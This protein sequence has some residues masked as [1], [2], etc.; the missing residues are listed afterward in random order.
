[1]KTNQENR[2]VSEKVIQL[3]EK[4]HEFIRPLSIGYID[5]EKAFNSIEHEVIF[6]ALRTTGIKET[7][8]T[9][10]EDIY[11][12]TTARVHTDNQVSEE[13]SILRGVRQG[14]QISPKSFIAAIQVLKKKKKKKKKKT[15]WR[16]KGINVDG[17]K[18]S[19]IKFG[20]DAVLTTEDVKYIKHQLNTEWRKLKDWFHD[21]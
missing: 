21:T 18:L 2:M 8:I 9:I 5:Y 13:I 10:L 14:D 17:E 12:G 7:Y 4:C 16:Q 11:T 1:M 3:T 20:D 6:K 19:D 15:A